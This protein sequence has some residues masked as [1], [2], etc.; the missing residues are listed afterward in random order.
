MKGILTRLVSL[1]LLSIFLATPASG[2]VRTVAN[3]P[4]LPVAGLSAI[5]PTD[6]YRRLINEPVK[7]WI[8]VRGQVI[9]NKVFGARISRSEANGVYDKVAVQMANGMEL[10]SNATGSRL[11]P[12]FWSTSSFINCPKASMP[13]RSRKTM[14][15]ARLT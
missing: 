4:G 9:D 13:L 1:V 6:A 2:D 10:C 15:W 11:P 14:P 8:I 3:L 12:L 7:A 5:L